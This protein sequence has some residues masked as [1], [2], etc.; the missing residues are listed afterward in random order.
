M[1]VEKIRGKRKNAVSIYTKFIKNREWHDK[2]IFCFFEG[3]DRKYY[4]TRIKNNLEITDEDMVYYTCDGKENVQKLYDMIKPKYSNVKKMFFI[5]KDYDDIV[6]DGELYVTPCYSLENH[7]VSIAA[8][9][10][11]LHNEFGINDL[12]E[13][14]KKCLK[15]FEARKVEFNSE[16]KKLNA[17]IYY[18]KLKMKELGN[19]NISY[20]NF[21]LSKIFDIKIE[22]LIIK[23]NITIDL[24]KQEYQEA[25][26]V[27]DAELE[28]YIEQFN[29]EGKLRGK[30]QL[31]FLEC[32]LRDMIKK[33]KDEEYFE[34]KRNCIYLNPGNNMISNLADYADTPK[35]LITFLKTYKK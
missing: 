16:I 27:S 11:I 13:D 14:Y 20:Q 9:K 22:E 17:W 21:K 4:G 12:D 24:L 1:E 23:R 35:E 19:V 31:K 8:F 7:Y 25:Y 10:K 29:E 15:D 6:S 32:I 2:K 34:I 33:N 26:D 28:P 3:E 30:Y 5:D 18:Q